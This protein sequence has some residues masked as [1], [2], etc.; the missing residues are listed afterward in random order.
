MAAEAIL[1]RDRDP[2]VRAA[3]AELPNLQNST[4]ETLAADTSPRVRR[5]V[6]RV[7]KNVAT[8]DLETDDDAKVRSAVAKRDELSDA[9]GVTESIAAVREAFYNGEPPE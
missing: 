6:A 7:A 3:L 8:L 1:V 4:Y 2:V 9:E 5:V